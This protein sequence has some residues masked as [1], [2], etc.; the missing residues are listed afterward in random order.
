MDALERQLLNMSDIIT[1]DERSR[2]RGQVT[3]DEH[4]MQSLP[5]SEKLYMV[6]NVLPSLRRCIKSQKESVDSLSRNPAQPETAADPAFILALEDRARS[7]GVAAIGYAKLPRSLIFKNKGVLYENAIVVTMEMDRERMGKAPSLQALDNVIKTYEDLGD[8][9]N[10]LAAFLR[11]NGYGA[12][13]S[14]ALGGL[15]FYPELAVGACM[16]VRGR[17]GLLISP[18]HGPR[19]RIAAVFTSI[20]NLPF[21]SGNPHEWVRDFCRRCG[22]CIKKCPAGAIFEKPE[23]L[24]GGA[25]RMVDPGRCLKYFESHYGCSV[26]IKECPFNVTGYETIKSAFDRMRRAADQR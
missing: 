15:A 18:G 25:V 19:Q 12:Q 9:V 10:R 14:P 3:V 1:G 17:H 24:A 16:G 2:E 20:A 6:T 4:F 7:L 21:A 8:I 23:E 11:E 5:L 22:R 13:A 26:C